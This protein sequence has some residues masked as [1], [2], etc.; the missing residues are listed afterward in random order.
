MRQ[1]QFVHDIQSSNTNGLLKL[2]VR[3]AH[4]ALR[5]KIHN[6]THRQDAAEDVSARHVAHV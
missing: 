1:M 3:A 2:A 5:C 6:V 4:V